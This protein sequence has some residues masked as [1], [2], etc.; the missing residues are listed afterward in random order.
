MDGFL[1]VSSSIFLLVPSNVFHYVAFAEPKFVG[2]NVD[3]WLNSLVLVMRT[4]NLLIK[5]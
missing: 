5:C 4:G 1:D 3:D 2:M